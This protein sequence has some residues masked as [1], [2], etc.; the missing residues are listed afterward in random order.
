M[1][2]KVGLRKEKWNFYTKIIESIG[3]LVRESIP[4]LVKGDGIALGELCDI[5]HGLLDALGVSS[6]ELNH[7]VEIA[8]EQ[9]AWGAK[10]TGGGGGGCM[11]ALCSPDVVNAVCE[12]LISAGGYAYQMSFQ[13]IGVTVLEEQL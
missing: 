8:R 9:G 11:I 5:N 1:V 13:P 12:G 2:G 7:F 10:L 4:L 6:P 3:A